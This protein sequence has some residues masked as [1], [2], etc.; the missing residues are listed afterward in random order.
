MLAE[1]C[2]LVC[3]YHNPCH[4]LASS[5]SKEWNLYSFSLCSLKSSA[6]NTCKYGKSTVLAVEMGEQAYP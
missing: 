4:T 3:K 6:D 2:L 1:I 5:C